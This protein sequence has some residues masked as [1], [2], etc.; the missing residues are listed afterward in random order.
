MANKAQH[1]GIQVQ[2]EKLRALLAEARERNIELPQEVL[3]NCSVLMVDEAHLFCTEYRLRRLLAVQPR[4]LLLLTATRNKAN[5]MEIMMNYLA[6]DHAVVKISTMPFTVWR[7]D[8]G[9]QPPIILNRQGKPD[10]N[11]MVDWIVN[12][13]YRNR[14]IIE[15]A[16]RNPTRK[17]AIMTTRVSHAERLHDLMQERGASVGLLCGNRRSYTACDIVIG[18]ISKMGTGFDEKSACSDF[19]GRRINCLLLVVSTKQ[20]EQP[21]GRAFRSSQ[22]HIV[23][24]VDRGGIFRRHMEEC[25]RWYLHPER[26]PH[27][28]VEDT[29]DI[30]QLP[31]MEEV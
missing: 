17:I 31:Y 26:A 25:M 19:D 9:I 4:Y 16:L 30:M 11:K 2:R 21:A 29:E 14:L 15:W 24:F 13:D 1:H 8:T 18:T 23:H 22:P 10:W 20:I 6:G 7:Y 5:G 3:D 12:N 28:K 27:V